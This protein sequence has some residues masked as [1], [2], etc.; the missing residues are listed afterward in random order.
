MVAQIN[1]ELTNKQRNEVIDKFNNI[2]L[3]ER[4]K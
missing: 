4:K 1:K 2:Q 3:R